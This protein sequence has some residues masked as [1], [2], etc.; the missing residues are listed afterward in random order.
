[1][2]IAYAQPQILTFQ[3]W[4]HLIARGCM[5]GAE[6]RAGAIGLLL[7]LQRAAGN[8]MQPCAGK[9]SRDVMSTTKIAQTHA[10]DSHRVPLAQLGGQLYGPPRQHE[11]PGAWAGRRHAMYCKLR[12]WP[13]LLT[14]VC[15]VLRTANSAATRFFGHIGVDR[16]PL[17]AV[18]LIVS[19]HCIEQC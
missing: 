6:D 14:V 2:C 12:C 16:L 4:M 15:D 18:G 13:W 19:M 9:A 17:N 3:G 11:W 7:L 1:M 10:V 8:C 5:V